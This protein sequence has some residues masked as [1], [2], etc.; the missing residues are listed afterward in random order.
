MLI[1]LI[2]HPYG[3]FRLRLQYYL[4]FFEVKDFS[5][6]IL[7]AHIICLRSKYIRALYIEHVIF[8]GDT[9]LTD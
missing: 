1:S 4:F 9:K 3:I 6:C 8:F 5:A 2:S 7:L